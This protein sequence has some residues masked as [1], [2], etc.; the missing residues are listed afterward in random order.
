MDLIDYL[1]S[2]VKGKKKL[3]K[4]E[5]KKFGRNRIPRRARGY[6]QRASRYNSSN[7]SS[8]RD[9]MDKQLL[10]LLTT[11]TKQ[12][13]TTVDLSNPNALNPFIEKDRQ[14]YSMKF[15]SNKK[16]D[17]ED[18][19]TMDEKKGVK[20]AITLPEQNPIKI[21][22]TQ[23]L[24]FNVSQDLDSRV[25]E[26]LTEQ[27]EL[28]NEL[29]G[30]S[31]LSPEAAKHFRNKNI[32]LKEQV[33][34]ETARLQEMLNDAED[35]N[36]YRDLIK[37]QNKMIQDTTEGFAIVDNNLSLRQAEETEKF[38]KS[39]MVM[40]EKLGEMVEKIGG[41]QEDLE[42]RE[43]EVE[44]LGEELDT[45]KLTLERNELKE[46]LLKQQL[47]EMESVIDKQNAELFE[48]ERQGDRPRY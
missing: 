17:K 46:Q 14:T 21:K 40:G 10:A 27:R 25:E 41:R 19:Y 2:Y 15:D 22:E 3:G 18:L 8:D 35:L 13:Q 45:L 16:P 32:K 5:K 31:V 6:G 29:E 34:S 47:T 12:N 4:Q 20:K 23:N 30:I 44:V 1:N 7:N 11:L 24:I 36:D 42:M 39:T 37:K 26:V 33:V 38:Q 9:N 28:A 43:A 48:M